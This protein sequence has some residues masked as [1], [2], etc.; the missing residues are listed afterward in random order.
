ML[1]Q[2]ERSGWGLTNLF[3]L[4][5]IIA[6]WVFQYRTILSVLAFNQQLFL[7]DYFQSCLHFLRISRYSVKIV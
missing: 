4:E 6:Y 7:T 5:S 2:E 3:S 1:C